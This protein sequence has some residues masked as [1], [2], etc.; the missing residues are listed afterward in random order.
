MLATKKIFFTFAEKT[1]HSFL[2][3]KAKTLFL[4]QKHPLKNI[5]ECAVA[6]FVG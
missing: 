2:F 4:G 5:D 3:N 6:Q 1:K